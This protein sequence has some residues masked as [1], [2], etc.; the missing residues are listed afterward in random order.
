M[1][2]VFRGAGGGGSGR[3]SMAPSSGREQLREVVAIVGSG[4]KA[5]VITK[6]SLPWVEKAA[7]AGGFLYQGTSTQAKRRNWYKIRGER[8]CHQ[9]HSS[10][11]KGGVIRASFQ[12]VVQC[13]ID[14]VHCTREPEAESH[15]RLEVG[16]H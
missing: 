13:T 16:D 2:R 9:L 6:N 3:S 11:V 1:S 7:P 8:W 4:E 14:N 12:H 5:E 15:K 10:M